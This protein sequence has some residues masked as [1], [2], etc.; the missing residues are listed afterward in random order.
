MSFLIG[1]NTLTEQESNKL[2]GILSLDEISAAL[3]SMKNKKNAQV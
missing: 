2:E 3:K 1:L